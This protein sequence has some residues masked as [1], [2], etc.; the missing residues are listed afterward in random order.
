MRSRNLLCCSLVGALFGM[1]AVA[2]TSNPPGNLASLMQPEAEHE[3]LIVNP[4]SSSGHCG[5]ERWSVKTGTDPDAHLVNLAS[6]VPQSINYLGALPAPSSPPLNARVQ[7]T[8]ITTF[9]VDATLVQYKLESDSDYH[10]VLKD[11][12][13]NTMIA[14]I[15]DPVCVG[16][17][18]PL[19]PG[20]QNARSEFDAKYTST[21][22]FQT[23]NI[24]VE[25]MGIG[26]FDFLHGQTGV[27]PNGI[28]LHPVINVVFN[29][30]GGGD[31]PPVASFADTTA[32]LLV[33][34]TNTSTDSDGTVVSSAWN[35]GDGGTSATSSPSHA[36]AV[37]GTYNVAL[38]VTDN[39]GKTSAVT[40]PVMVSSGSG[41]SQLFGNPG[42]E[43][44]TATPWSISAGAL[45]TNSACSGETAHAGSGFV[46]LDGYGSTHVDTASQMVTI[47]A[48]DAGATLTFWLHVDTSETSTTNAY[49]TL[50]VQVFDT[51]GT[52]LGTMAQFSNL[53]AADGYQQH[54]VNLSA[55]IGKSIVVKFI[56]TEDSLDQTSF[57]LDDTGLN[58]Q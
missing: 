22:S 30:S 32:G 42:F 17:G 6:P 31:V 58:V 4:Y 33:S 27:A 56:G 53:D 57:V 37:A 5:V 38:T 23:A 39:G 51:S 8:E 13:G 10:L 47:P 55:Y 20:I 45:C 26:F 35:F 9:V 41:G 34:F 54:S 48:G 44:S 21:T 16:A 50:K 36:Y 14:E 46:W 52:L 40:K 7:P 25:I 49:D 19:A 11:A 18:S 2:S 3:A 43:N 28:E 29:P 1:T 15:P 12:Q 24:P